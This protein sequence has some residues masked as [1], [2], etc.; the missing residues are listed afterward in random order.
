[1]R[2]KAPRHLVPP[3]LTEKF[4]DEH[5]YGDDKGGYHG[6]RNV[7][8]PWFKWRSL[9]RVVNAD[10]KKRQQRDAEQRRSDFRPLECIRFHCPINSN[11]MMMLNIHAQRVER[12]C[13]CFF[14]HAY[15][16]HP[17]AQASDDCLRLS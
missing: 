3:L 4:Y 17:A 2:S 14:R 10:G 8:V 15:R 5:Q 11:V 7:G 13:R 6:L 1:M 9:L 12:Y 16:P